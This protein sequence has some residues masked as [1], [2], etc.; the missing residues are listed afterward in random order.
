M[1]GYPVKFWLLLIHKGVKDSRE[2]KRDVPF[3]MIVVLD[4]QVV[5]RI[6]GVLVKPK[7]HS[8]NSVNGCC[9]C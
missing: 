9:S 1:E 3:V 7:E 4:S 6:S 8:R 5:I 2:V